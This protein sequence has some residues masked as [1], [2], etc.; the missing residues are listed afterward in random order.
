M[1]QA[2]VIATWVG[3]ILGILVLAGTALALIR[4]SYTKALTEALRTRLDETDKELTRERGRR[5][6]LE[7]R[8][9]HVEAENE[10]LK[11]LVLQ[12]AEFEQINAAMREHHE[13]ASINWTQLNEK[14]E[15]F[16]DRLAANQ[17]Q[18]ITLVQTIGQSK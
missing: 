7:D 8:V 3:S 16:Y 6:R 4:G 17:T 1:N 5:E 10:T 14:M 9:K 11:N 13:Q 15:E 12:R 18:I 2:G